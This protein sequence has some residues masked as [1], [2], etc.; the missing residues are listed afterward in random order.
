MCHASIERV[1]G[2]P[3][4]HIDGQ[5]ITPMA[6]TTYLEKPAYLRKLGEAGI[7][8]FFVMANTD[9]LDPPR[10]VV[11]DDGTEREE[12]GGFSKFC[13]DMTRLL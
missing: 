11:G 5:P 13:T 1:N 12:P 10:H 6:M 2:E 8:L 7:R 9:W 3:V 4:I